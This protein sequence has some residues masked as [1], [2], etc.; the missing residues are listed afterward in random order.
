M[1]IVRKTVILAR[2]V[3]HSVEI[4][5][6]PV[7]SLVPDEL[8]DVSIDE[9]MSKL[10]MMDEELDTLYKEAASRNEVIK[11]TGIIEEDGKC[12]VLL[13]SYSKDHSFAG[14]SGTD[15]IVAFTTDRYNEQPLVI[16]GPGA[17]PHVTAGGVFADLL[18][19]ASYLGAKL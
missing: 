5:D 8:V 7:R 10:D 2:E 17:G 16:K 6:I 14:I 18:R 9:F 12:E 3:G 19:L 15:N 11:Y 1:D 4:D 13:K